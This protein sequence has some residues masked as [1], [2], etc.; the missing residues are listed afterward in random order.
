MHVYTAAPAARLLDRC[1]HGVV[2]MKHAV[3]LSAARMVIQPT[4]QPTSQAEQAMIQHT[5]QPNHPLS[6]AMRQQTLQEVGTLQPNHFCASSNLLW[7]DNSSLLVN[8]GDCGRPGILKST[9]HSGKQI[10]P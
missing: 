3:R 9:H 6:Q 2:L 7:L 1:T 8:L 10:T 5:K 4:N